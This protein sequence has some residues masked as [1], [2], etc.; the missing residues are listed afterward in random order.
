MIYFAEKD[1]NTTNFQSIPESFWWAIITVTTVGYGDVCPVTKLGK[2]VGALCAICGVVIV[3]LP[4]S[5][6]GS[7]FSYYYIQA[8]TRVQQPRRAKT[9]SAVSR[10]PVNVMHR[11]FPSRRST[12]YSVNGS[13]HGRTSVGRSRKLNGTPNVRKRQRRKATYSENSANSLEMTEMNEQ[14]SEI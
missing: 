4:V 12:S 8:R 14:E 10:V 13:V 9:Q 2:V 3:A 11:H 6:I 7:N 5:V 1:D